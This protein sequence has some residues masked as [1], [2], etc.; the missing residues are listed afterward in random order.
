[1][2]YPVMTERQVAARWKVSLK[3]LRRWRLDKEG[4]I[5]HKLFHHVRHH[6]ADI[7]EFERQRAQH[8]MAIFGDGERVPRAVTQPRCMSLLWLQRNPLPADRISQREIVAKFV[9]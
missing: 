5:W 2:H 3:T 4:P 9:R 7:F 1:M 6:E 8:W